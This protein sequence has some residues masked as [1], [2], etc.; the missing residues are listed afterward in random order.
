MSGQV[1]D[2]QTSF[3]GVASYYVVF[4]VVLA[5]EGTIV[6]FVGLIYGLIIFILGGAALG[7]FELRSIEVGTEFRDPLLRLGLYLTRRFGML[8]YYGYALTVGASMGGGAV[9]KS[10][11]HS[12]R[13]SITLLTAVLFAAI[14]V[15]LFHF[16]WK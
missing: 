10:L 2:K 6:H 9:L 15:P 1:A 14:W 4:L 3:V 16:V 8:G 11:N 13:V 7:V 5:G 12:R